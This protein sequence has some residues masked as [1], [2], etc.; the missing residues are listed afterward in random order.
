M[1]E[2][3]C[4]YCG[5]TMDD[6]DE[7]YEPDVSYEHECPHCENNFILTVDYIRIY[8]EKRA[9]CLNGEEHEYQPIITYPREYTKMRCLHC[10]HTRPC[11]E[12]EMAQILGT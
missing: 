8:S 12:Q 1:Y 10:D 2:C 6:P 4:P 5:K 9:D 7:C 3:T 11:T